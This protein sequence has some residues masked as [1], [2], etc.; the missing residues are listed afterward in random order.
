M[1]M[2]SPKRTQT[3]RSA[4]GLGGLDVNI[5]LLLCNLNSAF[6][7]LHRDCLVNYHVTAVNTHQ[8]CMSVVLPNEMLHSFSTFLESMGGFFRVVNN[9]ARSASAIVKAHD[10]DEIEERK[11]RILNFSS[12]ACSLFD[13]YQSKGHN[14][15]ESVKM[16]N[17]ALKAQ[18]NP[19]ASL[20]LVE[21]TLR[22]A[23]RL[24]KVKAK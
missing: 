24:R 3:G 5:D 21:K 1:Q 8:V 13:E 7:P 23:G 2:L 20:Y 19:W 17:F 4:V 16:T 18:G 9:K 22:A 15:R 10:L 12:E 11:Q 14:V 6:N